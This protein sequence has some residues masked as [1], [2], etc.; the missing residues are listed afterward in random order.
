MRILIDN[1]IGIEVA[2][3][4]AKAGDGNPDE[5]VLPYE[6]MD[7]L[8]T[9]WVAGDPSRRGSHYEDGIHGD[10]GTFILAW[11]VRNNSSLAMGAVSPWWDGRQIVDAYPLAVLA[12]ELGEGVLQWG[13]EIDEPVDDTKWD[14]GSW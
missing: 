1:H 6:E 3:R 2:A 4:W 9:A 10:L 13:D 7:K 14:D 8:V 11:V 12:S 5:L